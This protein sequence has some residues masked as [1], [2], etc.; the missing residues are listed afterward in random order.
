MRFSPECAELQRSWQR[1]N[2]FGAMELIYRMPRDLADRMH[3]DQFVDD[4]GI[5][6]LRQ[7]P[8]FC[9]STRKRKTSVKP[10]VVLA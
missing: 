5:H 3:E 1:P 6:E 9:G 8:D 7:G 2:K 4:M 10:R